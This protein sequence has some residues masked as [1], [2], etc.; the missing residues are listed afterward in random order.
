MWHKTGVMML[1]IQMR[2]T[3][4]YYSLTDIHIE[5]LFKTNNISQMFLSNKCSLGEQKSLIQ[6]HYIPSI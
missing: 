1:K 4:I 5:N 3:E 2:I 6:N